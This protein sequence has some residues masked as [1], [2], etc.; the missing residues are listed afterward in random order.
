MIVPMS[1]KHVPQVA[2]LERLC[3]SDPWSEASVAGELLNPLSNW[4]V[5]EENGVVA[6]YIGAQ[7]VHPEADVMNLAVAPGF[8]RQ[9]IARK[10]LNSLIQ[11]LHRQGIEALF[12][13]VRPSNYAAI[14]LYEVFGFVQVGRRPKYYVNPSEDALILRKE[15]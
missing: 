13:E 14:A 12:L 6:G 9:G 7:S 15:L 4:L 10:L 8:R 3:F 1:E 11:L 2:E 5:Y